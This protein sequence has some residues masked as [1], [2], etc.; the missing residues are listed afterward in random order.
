MIV[1][2][3]RNLLTI[4]STDVDPLDIRN[5]FVYYK[6]KSIHCERE[7]ER[8]RERETERVSERDT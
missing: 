4:K 1:S 2:T 8:E 3:E 5:T 6:H 7:G